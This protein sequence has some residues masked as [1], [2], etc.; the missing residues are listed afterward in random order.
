MKKVFLLTTAAFLFTGMAFAH[1]GD[2]KKCA[3]GKDCCKDM[4]ECKMDM[5]KDAKKDAKT[6]T[7]KPAA[8]PASTKA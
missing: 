8:K 5:K 4:K 1:Q 3:K 6:A 2:G 7:A